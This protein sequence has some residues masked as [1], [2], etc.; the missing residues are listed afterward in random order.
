VVVGMP[1]GEYE[2]WA[3]DPM[4]AMRADG[5]V[6][7]A[8]P[9]TAGAPMD[10]GMQRLQAVAHVCNY[11]LPTDLVDTSSYDVGQLG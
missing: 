4:L 9:A 6:L 1:P 3:G 11:S 8:P 2:Y 5:L 10:G 7:P